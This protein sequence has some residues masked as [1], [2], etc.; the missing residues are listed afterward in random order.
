MIELCFRRQ[1]NGDGRFVFVSLTMMMVRA[2]FTFVKCMTAK[3]LC[4]RLTR[5]GDEDSFCYR[6]TDDDDLNSTLDLRMRESS[7]RESFDSCLSNTGRS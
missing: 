1:C 3:Y 2:D 5:D 7:L 4:L 6:H